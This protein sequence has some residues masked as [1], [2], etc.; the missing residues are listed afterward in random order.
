[1]NVW[2]NVFTREQNQMFTALTALG[3]LPWYTPLDALNI[4]LTNS[5]HVA[6]LQ[7]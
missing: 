1:M 6:Y 3:I 7:F 5:E 2:K 4:V